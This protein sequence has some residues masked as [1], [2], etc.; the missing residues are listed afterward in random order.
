MLTGAVSGES[1]QA[2][3]PQVTRTGP[4]LGKRLK[5]SSLASVITVTER[6]ITR[7][8]V[9]VSRPVALPCPPVTN[10]TRFLP[11][12]LAPWVFTALE[13]GCNRSR[14]SL[15]ER[16]ETTRNPVRPFLK[17]PDH[18]FH[19]AKEPPQP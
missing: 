12:T 6:L 13:Y 10:L 8:L 15:S 17:P 1:A 16:C 2:L 18:R 3:L 4:P 7:G 11:P 5:V 14:R 9:P 19:T